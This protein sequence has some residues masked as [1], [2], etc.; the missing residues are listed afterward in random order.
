MDCQPNAG[1]TYVEGTVYYDGAPA[2]GY[3][4]VFSYEPDGPWATQPQISGP[5]AGYPGWDPGYYSHIIQAG[6]ARQG[7]WWFWIV[8][9][10][11][12]RISAMAFVHTDGAAGP[13]KCQ[14]AI[15]DFD[16]N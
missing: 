13:G 12:D 11:G 1:V 4:I 5:H 2:N 7:D 14:Q 16:T 6:T 15:I 9:D 8:D 10:Q 3:R